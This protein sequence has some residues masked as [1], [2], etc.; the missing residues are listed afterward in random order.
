MG[1]VVITPPGKDGPF[2]SLHQS[3]RAGLDKILYLEL[4]ADM[5]GMASSWTSTTA[6]PAAK[7]WD[8]LFRNPIP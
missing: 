6:E 5:R 4:T 1:R 3:G 8:G 7:T 2:P